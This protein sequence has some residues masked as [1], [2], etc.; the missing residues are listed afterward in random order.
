MSISIRNVI[1]NAS[2][3][4][5]RRDGAGDF[6]HKTYVDMTYSD[7]YMARNALPPRCGWRQGVD[8]CA[9]IGRGQSSVEPSGAAASISSA[10]ASSRRA[11]SLKASANWWY[12]SCVNPFW[13]L[14]TMLLL[15]F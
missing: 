13:R 9:L 7:I 10:C 2:W 3:F 15:S 12:S 5:L 14:S 11:M 4:P 8:V 1:D 6:S